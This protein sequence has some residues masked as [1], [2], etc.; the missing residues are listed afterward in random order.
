MDYW[1][2][3]G[4][5]K[6]DDFVR[7]KGEN[8]FLL[9]EDDNVIFMGFFL[10]VLLLLLLVVVYLFGVFGVGVVV[11]VLVGFGGVD[12]VLMD[13]V[14]FVFVVLNGGVLFMLNNVS[15]CLLVFLVFCNWIV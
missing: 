7:M 10:L 1:D 9:E 12:V 6:E 14:Y 8:S 11:V 5:E 2:G 13:E 15:L 3:S 4:G